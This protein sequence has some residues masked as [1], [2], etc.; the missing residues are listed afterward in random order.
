[1]AANLVTVEDVLTYMDIDFSNRQEDAA[2]MVIDGLEDELEAYLGRPITERSFT[3]QYVVPASH[4][5]SRTGPNFRNSGFNTTGQQSDVVMLNDYILYLKQ[6]P[7]VSITTITITAQGSTATPL[8]LVEADDF[9]VRKYG[10][11]IPTAGANDI[12]DVTYVAGVD[13]TLVPSFKLVILR[14]ATRELQNMH[15]DVVGV[16]DLETR[17]V[18]PLEIGFTDSEMRS[19]KRHRRN[20][21]GIGLG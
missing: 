12:I 8:T 1:V 10:V 2:Q 9:Y 19:V 7:V 14:A 18:A 17:N 4:V 21:V 20:R 3:E 13:G 6:S 15:D 16:K 5:G 11:D